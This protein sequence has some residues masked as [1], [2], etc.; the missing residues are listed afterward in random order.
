MG[1]PAWME[2][3]VASSEVSR[4]RGPGATHVGSWGTLRA[5]A[6][7]PAR[8]A[9]AWVTQSR[10]A[11]SAAMEAAVGEAVAEAVEAGGEQRQP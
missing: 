1:S 6:G 9:G 7:C 11:G 10:P 4:M 3:S 5:T 8:C 2:I